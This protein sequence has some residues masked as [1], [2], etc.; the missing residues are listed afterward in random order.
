MAL[1][2]PLS[3]VVG[4][5]YITSVSDNNGVTFDRPV[6]CQVI[7]QEGG[8]RVCPGIN[9]YDLHIHELSRHS[10]LV[11]ASL[12]WH[13]TRQ[14]I[15]LLVTD[16]NRVLDVGSNRDYWWRSFAGHSHCYPGT[17]SHLHYY[18]HE[19]VCTSS[20]VYWIYLLIYNWLTCLKELLDWLPTT[21]LC[22][23][24]H[25]IWSLWR[26]LD[27]RYGVVLWLYCPC[28]EKLWI[29][30]SYFLIKSNL[31]DIRTCQITM[32]LNIP[33]PKENFYFSL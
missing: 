11:A 7:W 8:K 28:L 24:V 21:R 19:S 23:A 26:V 2:D 4:V 25:V 13:S 29:L 5:K 22:G 31:I 10:E 30:R 6:Y 33:T 16:V 27:D 32:K 18:R 17:F 3:W 14:L 20:S 15:S 1:D 12:K 9:L